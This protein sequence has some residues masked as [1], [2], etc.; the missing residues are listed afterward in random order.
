MATMHGSHKLLSRN[1][2]LVNV[3][4]WQADG[5]KVVF[6]NGC[7][8]ILH[9]GHVEYLAAAKQLG[10]ILLIGLN[11]DASVRRLKGVHRPVCSEADRAAVLAALQAVDAV[12]LFEEDTPESLINLLLPDI[13]VKGADWAVEQ[14][15]GAKAVLENGGKV[16]TVPLLEGRSTS[17]IIDKILQLYTNPSPGSGKD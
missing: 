10:D 2:A 12:T 4:A 11:S 16:L 8:D 3:R 13:L 1:E 6:T 17:N 14:I 15:A 9:A 5:K 7:F